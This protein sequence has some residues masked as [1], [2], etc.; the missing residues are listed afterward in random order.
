[1]SFPNLIYGEYG[2][3][4]VSG[5]T[6]LHKL[7]TKMEL[8]D[9]RI[10]RYARASATAIVTGK[11]YQGKA[12]EANTAQ[13]NDIAPADTDVG[14]REVVVTIAG[15]AL[16]ANV[17]DDGYLV[18][19]SSIGTGIGHAY[20]IAENNSCGAGGTTTLTLAGNDE[21]K[22]A[23]ES[24]TT[25]VGLRKNEYDEVLLTTADTV[26]VNVLAG[27]SAA[28]AAASA[29]CW[30]QRRGPAAVLTDNTTLIIG[31]PCTAS[32][33]VVGAVGGNSAATT[34][35]ADGLGDTAIGM[36][37]SVSDQNEYSLIDLTLE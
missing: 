12:G 19:A 4:K 24:G 20:K 5:A 21:V 10:F 1:M 36:V 13:I 34:N 14:A 23:L 6:K 32:T 8:P 18:V 30:I 25:T 7:G 9:G 29:Y 35:V 31:T 11:L 37:M 28:A 16:V 15:T 22:V 33:T 26:R 3:E 27:V 17:F 2:D